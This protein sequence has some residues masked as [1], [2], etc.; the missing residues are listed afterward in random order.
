MASPST[1]ANTRTRRSRERAFNTTSGLLL[2]ARNLKN[3]VNCLGIPQV[4]LRS[5][6]LKRP[7]AYQAFSV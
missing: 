7:R 5:D 2:P 3:I 1:A 4:S 6:S